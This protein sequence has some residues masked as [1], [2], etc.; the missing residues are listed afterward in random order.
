[1]AAPA[2]FPEP[3]PGRAFTKFPLRGMLTFIMDKTGQLHNIHL[4]E[5]T[6]CVI[7]VGGL[8]SLTK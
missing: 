5:V 7:S 2:S 6:G 1:M 3:H 8:H 4:L